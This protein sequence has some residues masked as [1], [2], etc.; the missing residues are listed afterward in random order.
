MKAQRECR[1]VGGGRHRHQ[2]LEVRDLM[3]QAVELQFGTVQTPHA[4]EWL[5]DNGKQ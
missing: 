1:L 5:S 2:R 3:L 4:I